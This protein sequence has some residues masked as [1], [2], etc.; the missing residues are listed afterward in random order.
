MAFVFLSRGGGAAFDNESDR[1]AAATGGNS[2]GLTHIQDARQR[3][4]PLREFVV[5]AHGGRTV[6]GRGLVAG[7]GR[8]RQIH[9]KRQNVVEVEAR[10]L[11]QKDVQALQEESGADQQDERN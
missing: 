3:T 8:V 11:S 4:Q 5:E 7:I 1:A 2:R 9:G 6:V 10:V